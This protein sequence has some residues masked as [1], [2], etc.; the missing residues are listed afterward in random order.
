MQHVLL[1]IVD[2][3]LYD[4]F[5]PL[6]KLFFYFFDQFLFIYLPFF[7]IQLWQQW[8]TINLQWSIICDH[9][10]FF[11]TVCFANYTAKKISEGNTKS[12][13]D[14]KI[15]Y[16]ERFDVSQTP[17]PIYVS[18][19]GIVKHIVLL[20]M[21]HHLFLEFWLADT[22]FFADWS[23]HRDVTRLEIVRQ[24]NVRRGWV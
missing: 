17:D 7:P 22:W 13:Q 23:Q 1:F 18:K 5:G 4:D 24:S 14:K 9:I 3:S 12:Y 16:L 21:R 10:I 20:T 19:W 6:W 2:A 11:E 8:V 15:W